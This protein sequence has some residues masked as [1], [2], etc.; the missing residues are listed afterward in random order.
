M[1]VKLRILYDLGREGNE[2]ERNKGR[3]EEGGGEKERFLITTT[4]K[5]VMLIL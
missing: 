2:E 3:G 4:R 1:Y 5:S